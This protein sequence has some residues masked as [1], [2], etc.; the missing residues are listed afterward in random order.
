MLALCLWLAVGDAA[1]QPASASEPAPALEPLVSDVP[2][3]GGTA[4]LTGEL[5]SRFALDTKFDGHGEDVFE[6]RNRALLK[7]DYRRGSSVRAFVSARTDWFV[8]APQAGDGP[9]R[10]VAFAELREAYVDFYTQW[11]DLRIGN[12]IFTWGANEGVA[13]ADALNPIDTRDI[14][15]DPQLFKV[16]VLAALATVALGEHASL[17]VVWEP[18]FV[19]NKTD[20]FGEDFSALT[21]GGMYQ[22]QLGDLSRLIDPTLQ[23][24]VQSALVGTKL[25]EMSPASSTV[26]MRV[27]GEFGPLELAASGIFGWNRTPDAHLD[28]DLAALLAGGINGF[29]ANP[30]AGLTVLNKE[31]NGAT[32]LDVHYT[33]SGVVAFDGALALGDFTLKLDAGLNIS[34]ALYTSD[35]RTIHRAM[36][37]GALGVDYHYGD[38]FQAAVTAYTNDVVS[39]EAG[40]RLLFLEAASTS[41]TGSRVAWTGG[42][43]ALIRAQLWEQRVALT[44]VAVYDVAAAEHA[45]SARATYNF[46]DFHHLTAGVMFLQ[47]PT[48]SVFGYYHHN[49]QAWL[50]YR[51][52]F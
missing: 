42:V 29:N 6:W 39:L 3:V 33:R 12:Q 35:L 46:S 4:Q 45:L 23:A 5:I 28:P 13:V 21:P 26:G 37:R 2:V 32:L 11:I 1:S 16:P 47:G 44:G 50:E 10:W 31:Q 36:L 51:F 7:L 30:S 25:P 20:L 8:S 43:L 40:E 52:S 14:L 9:A 34:Q 49:N 15:A 18:F 27:Q 19:P 48:A 24:T 41:A 22:R 17:R 38:N